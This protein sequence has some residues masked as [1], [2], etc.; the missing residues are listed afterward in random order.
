MR[1]GYA[2]LYLSGNSHGER[3]DDCEASGTRKT[4]SKVGKV[5]NFKVYS[6]FVFLETMPAIYF[7]S[8]VNML[9]QEF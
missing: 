3:F 1:P 7:L 9:V 2:I 4:A 8:S 5:R 6:M